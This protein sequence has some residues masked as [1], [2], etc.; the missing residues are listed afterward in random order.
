MANNTCDIDNGVLESFK[1]FRFRKAKSNAALVLKIDPK[2]LMI[3]EDETHEN[4]TIDD[5]ASELPDTSPRYIVLSY[6]NKHDDGR[7]SYPLVGLFYCPDGSSDQSRMLYAS[8]KSYV[9]QK[10][11]ISGKIYDLNEAEELTDS[12]LAER[13]KGSSTRP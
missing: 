9:F 4:V 3:V 11:D 13:L 7:V 8:A 2:Q 1:K 12:W 10:A 6:E 5:L